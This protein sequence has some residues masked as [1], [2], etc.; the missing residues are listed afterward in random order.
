MGAALCRLPEVVHIFDEVHLT[1]G[2]EQASGIFRQYP[3]ACGD[4]A[5]GCRQLFEY[6]EHDPGK[7]R[8][9]APEARH[10]G[11]K[12]G[13]VGL[14]GRPQYRD[15]DAVLTD[16]LQRTVEPLDPCLSIVE[17]LDTGEAAFVGRIA[18]DVDMMPAGLVTGAGKPLV[19]HIQ[20]KEP[21][22]M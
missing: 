12:G 3:A 13:E 17:R 6:A 21:A 9:G 2:T 20:I 5:R 18:G 8:L 1:K 22:F 16:D 14:Q 10:V 11:R 15:R 7:D 19:E 4:F